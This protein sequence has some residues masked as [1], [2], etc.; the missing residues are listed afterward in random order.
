MIERLG[1]TVCCLHRTQGGEE[2][3]HIR[4]THLYKLSS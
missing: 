3:I 1:D 4:F 2:M